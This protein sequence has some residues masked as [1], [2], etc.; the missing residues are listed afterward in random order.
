MS[1]PSVPGYD[2][3]G[4]L[5]RGASA[6][7]WRARRRADGL[8]VAVKLVRPAGGAGDVA[9]VLAEAGLMAGL[10]HEHVLRLYDVLPLGTPEEPVVALVTQLAAGG[11]LAQVLGSRRL[12]SPG[13][14]VT[15]LHPVSSALAELH[16]VGV[17]H[18][19]L[20]PGNIMFRSDGMPLLGDLGTARVAGEDGLRG[21]GTGG[22]DG[23]VAPEVVEGFP[24]TAES[25]VY[26]VGALAWLSLVGEVPGPGF[27]RPALAE[28]APRLAPD[29]LDLVQ[30]CMS[31]QPE[32]RPAAEELGGLLLAV[33]EPEPVEVAPDVDA[34][35]GVTERLRQVALEDAAQ[36][37]PS[38]RGPWW[39]RLLPVPSGSGEPAPAAS[40]R[41][42]RR[43]RGAHREVGEGA[44][45]GTGRGRGVVVGLVLTALAVGAVVLAVRPAPSVEQGSVEPAPAPTSAAPVPGPPAR[46]EPAGGVARGADPAATS[47][48][49]PDVADLTATPDGPTE[50][51]TTW[52]DAAA[53][54]VLQDLLD[55]RA[56][57]WEQVDPDRLEDVVV[58][59]SPAARSEG[60]Q[61]RQAGRAGLTYPDVA[62]TVARVSTAS[63]EDGRVV[64]DLVVRREVLTV[65]RGEDVVHTEPEREDEVRVVLGRHDGR[66]L[67]QE[68]GAPVR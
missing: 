33:A 47:A 4:P 32:D 41:R 43:R 36:A 17:V 29:L 45:A 40:E 13:E 51:T 53:A 65:R 21:W 54:D 52:D 34:A 24:A 48:G 7:V 50:P 9:A 28:V 31:P 16:R 20:S 55:R 66:W 59:G 35:F 5:G 22:H 6:Q 2:V 30:R 27:D 64:A 1:T 39:G 60:A 63:V 15:V 58:P 25:D 10:R 49:P 61:L 26:Q 37:G 23:M 18:G 44:P 57:A 42:P 56:A 14:L 3:L 62:F 38:P 12:L 67:L 11:S 68:W 46:A 19:D 8:P